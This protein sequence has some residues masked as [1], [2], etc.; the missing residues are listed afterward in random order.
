MSA[1]QAPGGRRPLDRADQ[2]EP[3]KSQ[4]SER[5]LQIFNKGDRGAQNSILSPNFYK[6]GVFPAPNFVFLKENFRTMPPRSLCLVLILPQLTGTLTID[7]E[8]TVYGTD[9]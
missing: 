1:A 2:L 6:K 3:E 7:L 8:F 4:F 5:Q 9:L